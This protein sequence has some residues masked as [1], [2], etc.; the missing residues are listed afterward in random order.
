MSNILK[1]L[2][3]FAE[4]Q[5]DRRKIEKQIFVYA[6]ICFCDF[7]RKKGYVLTYVGKNNAKQSEKIYA[8]ADA[9]ATEE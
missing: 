9:T 8:S 3:E 1:E 6:V 5:A 7:L 2:A 4:T